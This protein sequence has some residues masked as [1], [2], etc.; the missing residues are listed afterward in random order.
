M[1]NPEITHF[2]IKRHYSKTYKYSV[3]IK[4]VGNTGQYLNFQVE[5]QVGCKFK[6]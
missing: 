5:E 6:I 4:T 3:K 1:K 2:A